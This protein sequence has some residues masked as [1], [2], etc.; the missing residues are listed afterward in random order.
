MS[1]CK[2]VPGGVCEH[3]REEQRKRFGL[4][5]AQIRHDMQRPGITRWELEAL[6]EKLNNLPSPER[7]HMCP[8]C[9][10]I[11]PET[12]DHAHTHDG[13]QGEYTYYSCGK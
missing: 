5:E 7:V 8:K 2:R 3:D 4:Q 11:L 1:C 13:S 12:E 6:E 10:C 9:K